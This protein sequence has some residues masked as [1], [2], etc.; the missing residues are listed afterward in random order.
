MFDPA[1]WNTSSS[2]LKEMLLST[3]GDVRVTE[4]VCCSSERWIE[5]V[6]DRWKDNA[7]K[8]SPLPLLWIGRTSF[9]K[10]PPAELLS[11]RVA[12][13]H[14]HSGTREGA[15]DQSHDQA[16]SIL[17]ECLRLGL[18]VHRSLGSEE[19]KAVIMEFREKAKDQDATGR[20]K[21]ISRLTMPELK[22]KAQELGVEFPAGITKGKP[23]EAGERL[24]EHPRQRAD[25]DRKASG[26]GVF[27]RCRGST[28]GG[29]ASDVI[30]DHDLAR[31]VQ[32]QNSVLA[33]EGS[34]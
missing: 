24:P 23:L 8:T 7:A 29:R 18:T 30:A 13:A 33:S 16:P 6:A 9:N 3:L 14:G 26:D 15:P 25:E 11:S 12:D 34:V 27:A 2:V 17:Q 21:R 22:L 5:T 4:A 31:A 28:G 32:Q 1:R 19:I 20:M 10:R